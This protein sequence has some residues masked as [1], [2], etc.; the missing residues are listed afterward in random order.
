MQISCA[1]AIAT[2]ARTTVFQH[3]LCSCL[4]YDG[5][6]CWSVLYWIAYDIQIGMIYNIG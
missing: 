3:P 6:L 5:S 2:S 4:R 1:G